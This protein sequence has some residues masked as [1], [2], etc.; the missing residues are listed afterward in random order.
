M[1]KM[2]LLTLI[3]ILISV[4]LFLTGCVKQIPIG[5]QETNN[6][7][8]TTDETVNWQTYSNSEY[9]FKIKYPAGWELQI[10][11]IGPELQKTMRFSAAFSGQTHKITAQFGEITA[12][13]AIDISAGTMEEYKKVHNAPIS[14][15]TKQVTINNY[16]AIQE[17][18]GF[19]DEIAYMIDHPE[20]KYKITLKDHVDMFTD[21]MSDQEKEE[22]R[23]T[24]DK[25]FS[26]LEFVE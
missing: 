23:K 5:K 13:A 18:R 25:V 17:K 24:V 3:A 10:N 14:G 22:A 15:T 21:V 12:L 11:Q 2:T 8:K 7:A 4:S 19:G 9:G 6:S 16:P 26:T 1:K 20:G